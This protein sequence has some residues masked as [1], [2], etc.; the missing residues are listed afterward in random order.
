[1][2]LACDEGNGMAA[3]PIIRQLALFGEWLSLDLFAPEL[4]N[5]SLQPGSFRSFSRVLESTFKNHFIAGTVASTLLTAINYC[6]YSRF[7]L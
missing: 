2:L 6:V 1:M 5:C 7:L 4:P 3:N